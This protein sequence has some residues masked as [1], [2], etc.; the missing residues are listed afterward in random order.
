MGLLPQHDG[1]DRL[2]G[3]TDQLLDHFRR[4][5]HAR[6]SLPSINPSI[7]QSINLDGLSPVPV[8]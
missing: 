3:I 2:F 5:R 1:V 6:L 7:Y 4:N 8:V